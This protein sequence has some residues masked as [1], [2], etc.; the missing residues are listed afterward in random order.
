MNVE[1]FTSFQR[2]IV[3]IVTNHP[4]VDDLSK[5]VPFYKTLARF[6][7]QGGLSRH[8]EYDFAIINALEIRDV[9]ADFQL[10]K[11]FPDRNFFL[12]ILKNIDDGYIYEEIIIRENENM[13][14]VNSVDTID[15]FIHQY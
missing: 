7:Y 3:S 13:T 9:A 4:S 14:M 15:K 5:N 1:L 8:P 6:L 11:N 2:S 12:I 10:E